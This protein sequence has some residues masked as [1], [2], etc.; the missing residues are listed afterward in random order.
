MQIETAYHPIHCPPL[1][2]RPV[3]NDLTRPRIPEN[4]RIRRM[5]CVGPGRM[6][7][8]PRGARLSGAVT[9]VLGVVFSACP[10][11]FVIS[12]ESQPPE[13]SYRRDVRLVSF[14]TGDYRIFLKLDCAGT[15]LRIIWSSL[16]PLGVR[17]ALSRNKHGRFAGCQLRL[18]RKRPGRRHHRPFSPAYRAPGTERQG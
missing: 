1:L 4:N 17:Y 11:E 7:S 3:R 5:R 15:K 2:C 13:K 9:R 6:P 12:L 18:I 16:S 14:N 8:R 10:F